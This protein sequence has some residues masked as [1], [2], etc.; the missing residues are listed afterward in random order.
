[1]KLYAEETKRIYVKGMTRKLYAV[2]RTVVL[3]GDGLSGS[4]DGESILLADLSSDSR[5][6]LDLDTR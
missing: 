5:D 4:E 3:N 6:V 1:M 2:A